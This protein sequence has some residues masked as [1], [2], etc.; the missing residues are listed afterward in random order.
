MRIFW[1]G[2][3]TTIALKGRTKQPYRD[4]AE[5]VVSVR[6]QTNSGT[7]EWINQLKDDLKHKCVFF[8]VSCSL[9][10]G[11]CESELHQTKKIN[12]VF[13]PDQ[14][15]WTSGLSWCEYTLRLWLY[16]T[17]IATWIDMQA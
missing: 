7:V 6:F 10:K 13:G 17:L 4:P 15:K 9:A 3:N 16:N 12:I 5:E 11:Q 14:S 8:T 1:A 2:V